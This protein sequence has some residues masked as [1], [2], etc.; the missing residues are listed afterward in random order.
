M[1]YEEKFEIVE[2][3]DDMGVDIIEVGF[4]IV[5]EGDFCVVFE[6]VK[7]FK[8]VCICGLVCVN[9][10]DIDCCVEVVKYVGFSCIYMF[11]GILFLY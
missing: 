5:F 6:I 7:C 2:M 1:I 9:F 8:N 3:F 4:L 11:I 10:V